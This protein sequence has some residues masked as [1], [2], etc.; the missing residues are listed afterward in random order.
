MRKK[1]SYSHR[2]RAARDSRDSS[3]ELAA[4]F[5]QGASFSTKYYK[6]PRPSRFEPFG[7]LIKYPQISISVA[8]TLPDAHIIKYILCRIDL[9]QHYL[10]RPNSVARGGLPFFGGA[11]VYRKLPCHCGGDA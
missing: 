6:G 8:K 11:K 9:F 10:M 4:Y 3:P 1:Y 2:Q 5:L 7:Q